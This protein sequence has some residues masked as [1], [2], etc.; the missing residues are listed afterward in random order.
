M[1]MSAKF[2]RTIGNF[3]KFSKIKYDFAVT[4]QIWRL[5]HSLFNYKNGKKGFFIPH[6]SN[7]KTVNLAQKKNIGDLNGP[8]RKVYWLKSISSAWILPHIPYSW[9]RLIKLKVEHSCWQIF[10]SLLFQHSTMHSIMSHWRCYTTTKLLLIS[11]SITFFL[12]MLHLYT[13]IKI[14]ENHGIFGGF[15]GIREENPNKK[16]SQQL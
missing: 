5:Y 15:Q 4:Y 3:Y 16:C 13:P 12:L 11:D 7:R 14:S 10:W 1:L 9:S 2:Y 6:E 8:I